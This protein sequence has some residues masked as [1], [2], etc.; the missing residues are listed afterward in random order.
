MI[1]QFM[2]KRAYNQLIK[3]IDLEIDKAIKEDRDNDY[4]KL[5]YCRYVLDELYV[6]MS[7]IKGVIE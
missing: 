5:I 1:K 4:D 7:G 3:V 6:M 2:Y